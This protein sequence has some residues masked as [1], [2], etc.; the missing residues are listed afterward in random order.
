MRESDEWLDECLEEC[1]YVQNKGKQE[2]LVGVC[3]EGAWTT[4]RA[5]KEKQPMVG[6]AKEHV[7]Y[8]GP[9]LT[10]K[11]SCSAELEKELQPPGRLF[12]EWDPSGSPHLYRGGGR[13]AC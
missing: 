11:Q 12:T 2:H 4:L 3:G 7:R 5:I 9:F 6:A 8:L 10:A 1:G 13:D